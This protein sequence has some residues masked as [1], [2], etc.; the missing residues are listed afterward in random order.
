M[1]KVIVHRRA[2]NYL[3]K[4]PEDQK[5]RVKNTL[6]EIGK[7]PLGFPGVKQ[8]AGEWAGYRRIRLRDIRIIY[9]FDDKDLVD[10]WALYDNA[11]EEPILINEGG[12]NA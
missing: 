4:L 3:K 7:D 2:V 11:G 5:A 9:W 8:M 12:K 1:G 6:A 10:E